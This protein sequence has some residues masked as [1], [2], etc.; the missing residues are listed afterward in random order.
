MN[1]FDRLFVSVVALL[2][3]LPVAAADVA[4]AKDPAGFKRFEG[5]EIVRYQ[6]NNYATYWMAKDSNY[7][8]WP[9]IEGEVARYIY[10]GPSGH[11][12]L[13]LLRN[14]QE[15]LTEAGFQKKLELGP[16]EVGSHYFHEHFYYQSQAAQ[17]HSPWDGTANHYYSIAEGTA[18]GHKVTV[19]LLVGEGGD[20]WPFEV[21]PKQ[22]V[23]AKPDQVVLGLDVI[24]SKA[25]ANKMV[26][27]QASDLADALATKGSIDLYGIYFDTDKA[28][29]KPES[30]AT[31]KE[32][33]NL[34]KIDRSLKLEVAGHTDNTGSAEHNM[35]LS[36]ERAES[37]VKEL[38]GTYG[39]D[40]ARLQAK[41]YGDTKSV[42]PNEDESGRAK[43]R[44]VE[45]KKT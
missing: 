40:A 21:G 17:P 15:M 35:K 6:R 12:S 26:V 19:V 42:A 2:V 24:T 4:G 37:V 30:A 13:E 9:T 5:S 28:D 34:L 44:R 11:S 25:I 18:D 31:L 32:I 16:T 3:G 41:G 14:Y 29:I 39:I 43:N 7:A 27:V 20:G 36:Q 45:L 22:T 10:L 38:T 1:L 23:T 33:A 8:D